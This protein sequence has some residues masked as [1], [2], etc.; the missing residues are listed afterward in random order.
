MA[1]SGSENVALPLAAGACAGFIASLRSRRRS[2]GAASSSTA[3]LEKPK[4]EPSGAILLGVVYLVATVFNK[5]LFRL[6]LVPFG[7]S[8]HLLSIVT[9]IA[10]LCYF[11][12]V[13][14]R[15]DKA[16]SISKD[17]W[18]YA[19]SG[20]GKWLLVMTGVAQAVTFTL[21]PLF[22]RRL[23]GSTVTVI[24]QSMLPFSMLLSF[25]FLGRRY[26]RLQ[27][28]GVLTV[29]I[30]IYVCTQSSPASG[31]VAASAGLLLA[32]LGLLAS[33]F[34]NAVS[35]V[36]KETSMI[37]FLEENPSERL[38]GN[39]VNLM[40]TV[41]QGLTLWVF[42]PVN[43]A[44]LTDMAPAAYFKHALA[45]ASQPGPGCLLLVY[46]AA[47]IFYVII[48]LAAITRLSSVVVLLLSTL[49]VPLT[50]LVFCMNLPMLGAAP[51][52]WLTM[53]GVLV[54][55]AGLLLYNH[56]QLRG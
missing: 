30:G 36:F 50:T 28:A 46:C 19:R 4:D 40:T 45:M 35:F 18:N 44:L 15:A 54:I 2:Q 26:D 25:L 23:P 47:N 27:F 49:A 32:S 10:Y 55:F 41:W 56:K 42:W 48:T 20:G 14:R 8:T 38:N 52:R 12:F 24:A 1:S 33:Y 31:Q 9:N 7:Q 13:C 16:G 29:V 3:S 37:R 43:F 51:F 34:F 5:V 22:A 21:M 17:A 11:L 39:V 53:L 6:T